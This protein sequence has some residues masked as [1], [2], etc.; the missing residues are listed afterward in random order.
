MIDINT[1]K[2]KIE[3]QRNAILAKIGRLK[4][5]DPFLTEDRSLIMEPGTD[6]ADL[7]SHE[8]IVVLENQLRRDLTEIES[9]LKKMKKGTYGICE[10]CK[11]PIDP[12]R[13][14]VKPQ[15]VYCLKC[16]SE[17]EGKK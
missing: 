10:R 6:A 3:S 15:A 16:E 2:A 13:L 14:E 8:Q 5:E 1:I 12:A 17:V 4:K 9:A 11:K 7:F